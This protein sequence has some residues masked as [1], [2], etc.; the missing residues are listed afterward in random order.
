MRK[1]SR[2]WW[3]REPQ[4]LSTF[5]L[6]VEE[7]QMGVVMGNEH[8][9]SLALTGIRGMCERVMST[10]HGCKGNGIPGELVSGLERRRWSGDHGCWLSSNLT[11]VSPPSPVWMPCTESPSGEV[12]SI[13][14]S[15]WT[16]P[17]PRLCIPLRP[18]TEYTFRCRRTLLGLVQ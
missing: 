9:V 5:Y 16:E 4:L 14:S 3:C 17:V 12:E 8:G 11:V 15:F 18:G 6:R 13:L 10:G 1:R 7:Q 2:G